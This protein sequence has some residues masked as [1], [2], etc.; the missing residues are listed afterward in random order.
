MNI[1]LVGESFDKRGYWEGG[2]WIGLF[3][4]QRCACKELLAVSRNWLALGRAV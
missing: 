2:L 1:G 3:V 4:Y